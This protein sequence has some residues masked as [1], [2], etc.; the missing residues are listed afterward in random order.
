MAQP[1]YCDPTTVLRDQAD[2]TGW[3]AQLQARCL[4]RN[5]WDKIN[6]KTTTPLLL[7]PLS[8]RAL[9]ITNYAPATNTDILLRLTKLLTTG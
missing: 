6:P 2:W 7:K 9:T 1:A 5:I 3:L 8:L 4:L